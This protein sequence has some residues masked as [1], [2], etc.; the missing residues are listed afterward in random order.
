MELVRSELLPAKAGR[1]SFSTDNANDLERRHR[2]GFGLKFGCLLRPGIHK[3]RPTQRQTEQRE[4]VCYTLSL[5]VA[6][7]EPLY[8]LKLCDN[9]CDNQWF[10]T[11]I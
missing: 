8:E 11:R 3:C 5:Y 2:I 10:T 7:K 6:I 9:G 1:E 4:R